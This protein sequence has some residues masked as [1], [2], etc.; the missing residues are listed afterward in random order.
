MLL[1]VIDTHGL[2]PW[3]VAFLIWFF[4]KLGILGVYLLWRAEHPNTR[5]TAWV[6]CITGD[7]HLAGSRKQNGGHRCIFCN[8]PLSFEDLEGVQH[9][10]I[11]FSRENRTTTR[12]TWA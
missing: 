2:H 7:G 8:D 3:L 9:D 11:R 12:D 6:R 4:F 1:L 5:F 10:R